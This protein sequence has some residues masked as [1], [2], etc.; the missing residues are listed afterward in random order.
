[1]QEI[2]EG[3]RIIQ[4]AA[5]E[6]ANIIFGFVNKE[7]L[8]EYISYTVIATGF[9]QKATGKI[10]VEKPESKQNAA[11]GTHGGGGFSRNM[12]ENS[13]IT[14]DVNDLDIPTIKRV[15][16]G[17][18]EGKTLFSDNSFREERKASKPKDED[19]STFLRKI[20]D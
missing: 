19:S 10:T 16:G 6:E 12:F 20:M 13:N 17:S 4:E 7:E 1:M 15:Q 8:N 14:Y 5:G 2:D 9:E 11:T 18:I 3:N